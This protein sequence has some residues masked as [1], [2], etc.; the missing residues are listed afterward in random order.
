MGSAEIHFLPGCL[1]PSAA[2]RLVQALARAMEE[3]QNLGERE[4]HIRALG[5]SLD[6]LCRELHQAAEALPTGSELVRPHIQTLRA[7]AVRLA[8]EVGWFASLACADRS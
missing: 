3:G 2:T 1:D 4:H 8:Q 6:Q 5:L 7:N